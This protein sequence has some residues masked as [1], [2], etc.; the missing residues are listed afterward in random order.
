MMRPSSPRSRNSRGADQILVL[1]DGVLT[2][3][4]IVPAARP[5]A[6]VRSLVEHILDE[7]AIPE[8][9]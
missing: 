2:V 4:A 5:A 7:R 8:P 3:G 6:A 9:A 1:I